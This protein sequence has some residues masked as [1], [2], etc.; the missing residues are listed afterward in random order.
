MKKLSTVF[1]A[2]VLLISVGLPVCALNQG[3]PQ[4]EREQAFSVAV[5]KGDIETAGLLI[6]EMDENVKKQALCFS[7][8]GAKVES[9]HWD[10]A[11]FLLDNGADPNAQCGYK[12][13]GDEDWRPS[14][15][16]WVVK[17]YF[18]SASYIETKEEE[19]PLRLQVVRKA[20]EK[21]VKVN[22]K[23]HTLV[24]DEMGPVLSVAIAAN[25]LDMVQILVEEGKA[26]LYATVSGDILGVKT[27]MEYAEIF[28]GRWEKTEIFDYLKSKTEE[29]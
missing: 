1:F 2:A 27:I 7:I 21:G 16:M 11:L 9:R 22:E 12:G 24:N 29:Q 23:Y 4:S 26:D 14:F 17:G 8:A 20:I 28:A 5:S 13:E 6:G 19:L 25:N 15:L 18:T 10:M 3:T